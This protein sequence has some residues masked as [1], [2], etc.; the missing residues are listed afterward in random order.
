M[1]LVYLIFMN[2]LLLNESFIKKNL[3]AVLN[4]RRKNLKK[5]PGKLLLIF[6]KIFTY[7]TQKYHYRRGQIY[8]GQPI[9]HAKNSVKPNQLGTFFFC[10]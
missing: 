1:S 8:H 10:S 5:G 6:G 2:E 4:C 9:M 3:K 7:L